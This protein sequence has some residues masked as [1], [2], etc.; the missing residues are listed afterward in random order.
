MRIWL[1]VGL[2]IIM[3][4]AN[5]GKVIKLFSLTFS[6]IYNNVAP[7][8]PLVLEFNQSGRSLL[9]RRHHD[10]P[11]CSHTWVNVWLKLVN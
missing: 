1:Y 5:E 9:S 3:H 8:L 4:L 7:V 6:G 10:S 2:E 11:L